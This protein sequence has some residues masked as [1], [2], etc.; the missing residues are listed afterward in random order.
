MIYATGDCHGDFRRFSTK[1]FPEQKQMTKADMVIILGDF[2]GI[3]DYTGKDKSEKYW[4]KWLDNKNFTTI[5]V[6]GNHEC[7]P[8]LNEYPVKE[9]C[10]GKVHEILPSVL[11]LMRGEVFKLEGKKFFTFGGASS[12]DVQDGILDPVKDR[13][14]I[15]RWYYDMEKRFRINGVNWWPQELPSVEEM[16]NGRRN[17]ERNENKVDFVLSHSAP[18]EAAEAL[19]LGKFTA[20]DSAEES[21]AKGSFTP[22][23]LT[24]YFDGLLKDGL[25]FNRW[26]FG[27]YHQN[28]QCGEKFIC[29]YE[30]IV[31]IL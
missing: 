2:G 13:A 24:G 19:G 14:K 9:F 12:H 22:D 30:Q 28:C 27:H 7:F 31:R 23:C 26:L 6:D 16:E 17:L 18:S 5:F 3:W 1:C 25:I 11:H 20:K 15:K 10:G 4:L 21:F 29:L 8:R